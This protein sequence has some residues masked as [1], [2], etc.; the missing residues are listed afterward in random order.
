[1]A[2]NN[3]SVARYLFRLGIF[4]KNAIDLNNMKGCLVFQ[5]VGRH[6]FFYL[7]TLLHDGIYVMYEITKIE[8][9]MCISDLPS[10]LGQIGR[11]MHVLTVYQTIVSQLIRKTLQPT[12]RKK[13]IDD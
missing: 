5:S 11:L 3:Y 1:E 12:F 13:E 10:Y 8:I 7:V 4:A 6:T 9:P 2:N